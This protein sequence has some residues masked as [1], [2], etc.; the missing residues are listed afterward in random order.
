[1]TGALIDPSVFSQALAT[2]ER[3]V[4]E[5]VTP[6]AQLSIR[7]RDTAGAWRGVDLCVGRLA[8][9]AESSAVRV[10]TRYDLASVSKAL[11]ALSLERVCARHHVARDVALS[12]VDAD[13]AHTP[14]AYCTLEA[15]AS[16]RAG[17]PA[18]RAFFESVRPSDAT[19]ESPAIRARVLES[20]RREPLVSTGE[21]AVYSDVGYILLGEALAKLA[22]APLAAVVSR[23][24]SEPLAIDP[25][26]LAY[27]GSSARFT[28]DHIAPT[29]AC[30]WR[31]ELIRGRVHD[32]NAFALGGVAGHAGLF[33]TA[34]AVATVGA[35]SL[36]ALEGDDR[37]MPPASM[38]AMCEARPG[39]SHRLG[40]DGRSPGKSSAGTLAHAQTFGHLGFTGTSL[41][42]DPSRRACV[43]LLTNRVHPTRQREGIFGLRAAVHD[44]VWAALD[45][46]G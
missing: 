12:V 25:S 41:W 43:A 19:L 42:C 10:E 29:E 35:A 1:M 36:D 6:G 45:A 44:A 23:E 27:R 5:R 21:T 4:S 40:W 14:A 17:L 18:W 26:E 28:D 33:G 46:L 15:L 39:G 2:L 16:H 13:A 30:G 11:V 31:G 8:Y 37:W 22:G 9:D 20:V 7:V 38:R 34:R 32:E 24:V 3:G